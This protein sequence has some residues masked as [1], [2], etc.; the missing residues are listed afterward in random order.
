[1]PF[2][3]LD[4]SSMAYHSIVL[5][6]Q[7][8]DTAD[9]PDK[10]MKKDGTL[11]RSALPAVFNRDDLHALEMALELKEL[12]GGSVTVISMGPLMAGQLLREALYRGADRAILLTDRRFAAADTLATS[13]TLSA[14]VRKAGHF[15]L[16]LCGREASDGNTA[17]VGP[18]VAEK[19]RIPQI[20]CVEKICS[21]E[22]GVLVAHHLT[23]FGYERVQAPLPLLITVMPG[24]NE[25]RPPAA[26]R[27]MR[28]KKA[29]A[30]GEVHKNIPLDLSTPETVD[31]S[32]RRLQ[33]KGLLLT[34]WNADD[35]AI[36]PD[37]CGRPG[38]PTWVK[39]IERVVLTGGEHR[40]YPPTDEGVHLLM[41][42][43]IEEHTFG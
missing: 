37:R 23:D 38:S 8:P 31:S 3:P 16:I 27:L 34:Q 19:L 1:M 2:P 33:E 7:V 28:F 25:P 42:E 35:L 12:H 4:K 26:K 15:D 20:T 5:A 6:K 39:K 36:E 41:Q 10:A 32:C 22:Q 14:A 43:L 40:S 18:Q 24:S 30:P 9:V 29:L 17:Q 21:L 13:Y 11:D